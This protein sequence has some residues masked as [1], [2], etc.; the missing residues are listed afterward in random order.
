MPG[1]TVFI[2]RRGPAVYMVSLTRLHHYTHLSFVQCNEFSHNTEKLLVTKVIWTCMTTTESVIIYVILDKTLRR[3]GWCSIVCG[4][5][6]WFSLLHR[7]HRVKNGSNGPVTQLAFLLLCT[8]PE[9]QDSRFK[10]QEW[11]IAIS[12]E[13][14]M[15]YIPRLKPKWAYLS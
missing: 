6:N 1:K 12:T 5:E 9:I 10:I 2:L 15:V 8:L 3:K 13:I 14:Y 7:Q 11:F 4:D